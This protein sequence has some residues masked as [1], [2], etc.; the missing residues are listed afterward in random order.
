MPA[1]ASCSTPLPSVADPESSAEEEKH[2]RGLKFRR[3]DDYAIEL[4]KEAAQHL[5]DPPRVGQILLMLGRFYNPY[6]DAAIVD[7]ASRR[8]ILE[9]LERG[10]VVRARELLDAR[11]RL[12][13]RFDDAEERS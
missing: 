13:A 5:A 10:D 3:R 6:I 12:Y 8:E 4:L 9:S 7:P 2:R 1:K 11:L